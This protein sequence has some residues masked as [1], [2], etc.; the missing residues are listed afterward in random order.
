[1]NI[2]I[3]KGFCIRVM[4]AAELDIMRNLMYALTKQGKL[5]VIEF[6]KRLLIP[7]AALKK[8]SGKGVTQCKG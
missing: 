3:D 5:C 4:E 6:G 1:M 7:G 8:M 2:G